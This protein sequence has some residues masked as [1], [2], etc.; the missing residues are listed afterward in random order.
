MREETET[1]RETES[2]WFLQNTW[3][4]RQVIADLCRVQNTFIFLSTVHKGKIIKNQSSEQT[5]DND[6]WYWGC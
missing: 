5:W 4:T 2:L 3:K 1:E 6:V